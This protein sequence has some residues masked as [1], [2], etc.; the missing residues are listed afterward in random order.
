LS[1]TRNTKLALRKL[2]FLIT[3]FVSINLFGQ[4]KVAKGYVID[5]NNNV[6][7]EGAMVNVAET[8]TIEY[9]NDVGE[10][11]INVP[12]KHRWLLVS[13][14]GY[15]AAKIPLTPGFQ[16]KMI[17]VG[18]QPLIDTST[19]SKPLSAADS[20]FLTFKNAIS[21]SVFELINGAV[22]VR[23]ER[24]LKQKHSL[25]IH[26]SFYL[27]G[28]NPVTFGSEY[29]YYVR[30]QGIKMSPFYR[31][32]LLR[33]KSFGFFAEGKIQFGYVHFSELDYHYS[34]NTHPRVKVEQSFTSLG[35]GVSVG[36]MFKLPKTEHTIVNVSIGYQYFPIYVPE[37]IQ[38][39]LSDG[40]ILTLPTDTYWWYQGGP[41]T[42]VDIKLTIGGIF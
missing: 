7:I 30:Y 38:H 40:T 42:K 27:F 36:I 17:K 11:K 19:L 31:F 35:W 34:S 28:R 16:H 15:N 14:D 8:D 39:E 2:L 22:A 21:L 13:K 6:F 10:F 24:F 26:A 23:Y 1:I 4:E 12:K 5:K 9:T 33:K 18:I 3:L 29:D 37:T 32:Y 41:G 20:S 25:G